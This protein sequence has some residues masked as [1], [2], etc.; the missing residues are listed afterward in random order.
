MTESQLTREVGKMLRKDFPD[1]FFY[2]VNDRFHSGLPDFLLCLDGH[3]CGIELK[4]GKNEATK[5]QRYYI[6]RI[7]ACG[8]RAKVCKSVQEVRNFLN[9]NEKGGEINANNND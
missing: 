6:D 9:S 1:I 7:N 8:G 4:V 2:K 3:L 5:L